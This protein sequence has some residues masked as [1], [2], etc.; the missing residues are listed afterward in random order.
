M[1]GTSTVS[2]EPPLKK[3]YIRYY[4]EDAQQLIINCNKNLTQEFGGDGRGSI[5]KTAQLL[6]V[7]RKTVIKFVENG[8]PQQPNAYDVKGPFRKVDKFTIDLIS[9][10]VYRFYERKLAPTLDMVYEEV[11]SQT[12]GTEYE[13]PYSKSTLRRLLKKQDSGTAR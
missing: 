1:E 12:A 10:T 2:D 13:F 7:N 3:R 6:E 11:V 8:K 9:R 4:S 5:L